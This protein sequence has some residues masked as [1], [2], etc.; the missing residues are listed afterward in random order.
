MQSIQIPSLQG[1]QSIP[2][3]A[4]KET[5]KAKTEPSA[6]GPKTATGGG[7]EK[8]QGGKG[9]ANDS[10]KTNFSPVFLLQRMSIPVQGANQPLQIPTVMEGVQYTWA[11]SSGLPAPFIV[12]PKSDAKVGEQSGASTTSVKSEPRNGE[13]KTRRGKAALD[14]YGFKIKLY[15][16]GIERGK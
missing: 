5:V 16:V 2:L 12:I 7:G 3:G 13:T 4:P 11:S 1:L 6:A 14:W 15:K 8:G 9:Q 10:A